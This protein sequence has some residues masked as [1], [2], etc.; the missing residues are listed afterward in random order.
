MG[1]LCA[2]QAYCDRKGESLSRTT[3][4]G[5]PLPY[6]FDRSICEGGSVCFQKRQEQREKTPPTDDHTLLLAAGLW[7][8][9]RTA[10]I[11]KMPEHQERL[12]GNAAQALEAIRRISSSLQEPRFRWPIQTRAD[13]LETAIRAIGSESA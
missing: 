5:T 8:V 13:D 3:D 4:K 7:L 12:I 10:E 6:H 2:P 1:D 11:T 9:T